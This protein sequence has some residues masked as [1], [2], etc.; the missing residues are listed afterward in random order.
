MWIYWRSSP[1]GPWTV[2]YL[3]DGHTRIPIR[4]VDEEPTA[5]GLVH[6]LN[7]GEQDVRFSL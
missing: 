3:E 2:G 1:D 7:G 4:D 6:Y 5:A